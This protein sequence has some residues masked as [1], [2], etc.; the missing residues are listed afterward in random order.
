[1]NDTHGLS[2]LGWSPH[3]QGLIALHAAAGRIAGRVIRGDRTSSLVATANGIVRAG[4][5]ARLLKADESHA[6]LPVVGDWVAL[7]V[8]DGDG[9]ALIEAVLARRNAI[10]RSDAGRTAEVQALAANVDT[11][12][13][14]HPI[15][16]E[17]NLRRL[18]RGCRWPGVRARRRW[19]C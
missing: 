11:V 15:A 6:A 8:P 19:S 16:D 3:W 10:V 2:E 17:P 7:S 13:V 18:E 14:V 9:A 5:T 12:F 4:T 1:M